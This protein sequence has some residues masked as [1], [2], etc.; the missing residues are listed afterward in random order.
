MCN[1]ERT[2][3]GCHVTKPLTVEFFN[4]TKND[5]G[6][7]YFIHKCK[8]CRSLINK[9]YKVDNSLKLAKNIKDK[10]NPCLYRFVD[11]NGC[12]LY[13]GK[14]INIHERVLRHYYKAE[15]KEWKE[16]FTGTLEIAYINTEADMHI[17]EM[18]LITTYKPKFN[19]RD[20]AVDKPS[21]VLPEPSFVSYKEYLNGQSK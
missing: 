17:L 10:H 20:R 13:I 7:E 4:K 6:Y 21:F 12:I 5:R 19:E 1:A 15:I 3:K 11:I 16:K 14:T 2:C 9:Q 8:K 18:Y